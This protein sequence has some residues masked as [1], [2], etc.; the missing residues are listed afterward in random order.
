MASVAPC[1]RLFL[2]V[3][4][5]LFSASLFFIFFVSLGLVAGWFVGLGGFFGGGGGALRFYNLSYQ[6]FP[7]R[8]SELLKIHVSTVLP[9]SATLFS[10]SWMTPVY[11]IFHNL[12]NFSEV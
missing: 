6:C 10:L 4:E 11:R 2:D 9:L 12:V 5:L 3:T 8:N 7:S 1:N